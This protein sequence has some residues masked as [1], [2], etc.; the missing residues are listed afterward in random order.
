LDAHGVTLIVV[1]FFCYFVVNVN[2]DFYASENVA[3][4]AGKEGGVRWRAEIKGN[5]SATRLGIHLD[6]GGVALDGVDGHFFLA[7]FFL[8]PLAGIGLALPPFGIF[9]SP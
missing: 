4:E 2:E 8:V 5:F 9:M 1:L 7:G 6:E 3:H